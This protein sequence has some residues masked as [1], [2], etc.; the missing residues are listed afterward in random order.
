VNFTNYLDGAGCIHLFAPNGRYEVDFSRTQAL[1]DGVITEEGFSV[2]ES[3][4]REL[5]AKK[6]ALIE[7]GIGQTLMFAL[8]C[9]G[10]LGTLYLTMHNWPVWVA[11]LPFMF[12]GGTLL[13]AKIRYGR[14]FG[15]RQ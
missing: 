12:G 3:V 9:L 13:A 2:D 7:F 6:R 10:L 15:N 14:K 11:I 1:I 4:R 5:A 8:V